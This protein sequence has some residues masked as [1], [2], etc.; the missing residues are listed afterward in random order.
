M[1]RGLAGPDLARWI[2]KPWQ[3]AILFFRGV[4]TLTPCLVPYP[5]RRH[6]TE[7]WSNIDELVLA[8]ATM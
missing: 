2:E 4:A 1:D 6:R 3:Q 7:A 8:I 5:I